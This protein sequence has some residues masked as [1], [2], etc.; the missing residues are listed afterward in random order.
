[1]ECLFHLP[2]LCDCDQPQEEQL[3]T[4]EPETP[5]TPPAPAD[6][7][8]EEKAKFSKWLGEILAE[9]EEPTYTGPPHPKVAAPSAPA[10]VSGGMPDLSKAINDALDARDGKAKD[11]ERLTKIETAIGELSKPKVKKWYEPWTL[12]S[13]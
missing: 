2:E 10:P 12:F 1:V 5:P 13:G 9:D 6:A 11:G 8:P 7:T 4:K 3:M